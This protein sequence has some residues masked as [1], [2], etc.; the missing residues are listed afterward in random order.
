MFEQEFSLNRRS[1]SLAVIFMIK[2]IIIDFMVMSDMSDITRL[3]QDE[4]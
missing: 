2:K 1:E 4:Y 3:M